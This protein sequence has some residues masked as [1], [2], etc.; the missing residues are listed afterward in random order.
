MLTK[1]KFLQ[2]MQLWGVALCPHIIRGLLLSVS[3]LEAL[4]SLPVEKSDLGSNLYVT[5]VFDLQA[6]YLTS[7]PGKW[8]A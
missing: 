3:K 5:N 4:V 8:S 6:T 1:E 2:A 7:R